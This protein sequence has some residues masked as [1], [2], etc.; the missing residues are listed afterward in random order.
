MAITTY[1]KLIAAMAISRRGFVNKASIATQGAGGFTS[2]WRATGVPEQGATPAG[3]AT[4]TNATLGTVGQANAAS[5]NTLY[6]G[7][8]DWIPGTTHG[9][10][11]LD[12][13]SHM[14][15]LSGATTGDQAVSLTIPANRGIPTTGVGAIWWLEIYADIGTSAQTCTITYKDGLDA[16]NL[17]TTTLSLGGASP[18]N[19]DSR[20]YMVIPNA[21]Q[22]IK[23]ITKCAIAT[24]TGTAGS[25]GF[26]CSRLLATKQL[27]LINVGVSY[28]F[29]QIGM[30]IV[31][32]N[33]GIYFVVNSSTTSSGVQVGTLTF[34]EG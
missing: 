8:L 17:K 20:C 26:T 18:L 2:L 25:F 28:D 9:L 19:Q 24:T 29:A 21:G 23:E 32:D 4:V 22:S 14:G 27:G 15:G 7:A 3:A 12:R 6:I 30:P 33:S 10:L 13:L 11:V 16:D 5:G 1:D 34:I 31:Y